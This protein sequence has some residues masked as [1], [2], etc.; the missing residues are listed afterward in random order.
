M[1]CIVGNYIQIAY[2]YVYIGGGI[3]KCEL[4]FIKTFKKSTEAEM[5]KMEINEKMEKWETESSRFLNP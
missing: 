3:K 2:T 1:H 5:V 4:I